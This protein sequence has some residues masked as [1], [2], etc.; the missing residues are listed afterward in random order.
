MWDAVTGDKIA[1]KVVGN[2]T[3]L[4][5]TASSPELVAATGDAANAASSSGDEIQEA[6]EITSSS[7]A[8]GIVRGGAIDTLSLG[9]FDGCLM[10]VSVRT[11]PDVDGNGDSSSGGN[12]N[13]SCNDNMNSAYL[14]CKAYTHSFYNKEEE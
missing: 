3:M 4:T 14:H 9:T 7:Y 8:E 5:S 13:S 6:E 2:D 12:S 11:F 1:W 10:R